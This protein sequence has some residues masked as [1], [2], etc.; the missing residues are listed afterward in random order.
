M[1]DTAAAHGA[2]R[3]RTVTR[4]APLTPT[5]VADL[6]LGLATV[7]AEAAGRVVDR[8]RPPVLVT[9]VAGVVTSSVMSP[10]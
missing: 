5:D 4:F 8:A 3:A 9:A 2:G 6:L 7:G 10:H 1:D